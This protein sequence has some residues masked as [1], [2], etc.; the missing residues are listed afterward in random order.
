MARASVRSDS[1]Q[2]C[3]C[4]LFIC[5]LNSKQFRLQ[6]KNKSCGENVGRGSQLVW[7]GRCGHSGMDW[8]GLHSSCGILQC[9]LKIRQFY[10]QATVTYRCHLRIHS[11]YLALFTFP[12]TNESQIRRSRRKPYFEMY[13]LFV[14]VKIF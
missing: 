4:F 13:Q 9:T 7:T 2:L 8:Y 1:S 5:K 10:L 11:A 6:T 14:H 12:L 3:I